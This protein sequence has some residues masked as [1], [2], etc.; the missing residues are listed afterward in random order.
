MA[1]LSHPNVVAVYDVGVHERPGVPRD[2]VRRAAAR[3]A[4]G[5]HAK[6]RPWREVW[7]CSSRPARASPPR[8]PTGLVHRDFKPD[9]VLVGKDGRAE[10]HRL[11]PRR[12]QRRAGRRRPDR[13]HAAIRRDDAGRDRAARRPDR[14]RRPD[15]DR[16]ARR[17]A[18]VH[19]ARAVPGRAID[20][21]TRPVRVLRRALRGAVRRAA[22]RGHTIVSIPI[23][24]TRDQPP[25][26][27][28]SRRP[29][30]DP[31]PHPARP[32]GGSGGALGVDGVADPRA[33][34]RSRHQ[35]APALHRRRDNRGRRRQLAD[36]VADGVAPPR[37]G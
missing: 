7:R 8:T 27:Q 32:E 1:R 29:G 25:A 4:T 21:R 5:W 33:R 18:R 2:G 36:R 35:A 24:I 16:R 9:N 13:R 34:R 17:H 22:V 20:A 10:G 31:A 12:R 19:G 23:I 26:A 15:P 3:C 28:G 14:P 37:G 6:Q 11:R 30:V